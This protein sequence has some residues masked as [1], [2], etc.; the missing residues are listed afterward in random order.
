MSISITL[1]PKEL[2]SFRLNFPNMVQ[3]AENNIKLRLQHRGRDLVG[4]MLGNWQTGRLKESL[5]VSVLGETVKILIGAGLEYTQSVFSGA[6]PHIITPKT[7]KA[8]HWTR[9]GR[10]FFFQKVL[11]PGQRSRFDILIK[12]QELAIEVI[13]DQLE[14]IIKVIAWA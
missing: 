11:H 13:K 4:S 5:E 9:F 10:D 8:L 2:L 14:Q 6:V 12:L 7:G 1:T 3:L